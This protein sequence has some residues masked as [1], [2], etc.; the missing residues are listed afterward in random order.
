[1]QCVPLFKKVINYTLRA[2][3]WHKNC[4]LTEVTLNITALIDN[5]IIRGQL[6]SEYG[7]HS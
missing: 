4:F 3:S 7:V 6:C 2:V 5:I 1:M